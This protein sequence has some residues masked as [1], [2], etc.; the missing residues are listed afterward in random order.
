MEDSLSRREFLEA[1]AGVAVGAGLVATQVAASA[2]ESK[3]PLKKAL[4][5]SMLPRDLSME[6]KFQLAKAVGFDGVEIAPVDEAQAQAMR[7]AAEKAG[8]RIHSIIFG[9]WHAPLSSADATVIER[10]LRDMQSALRCAKT[11][12]ADVVLLVPAVVN[13][14]TRYVEA[15]ERSQKHIRTLIPLA[16]ELGVVIAVENVWNKFL[17]SP[18]EFAR[19]VDEFESPFVRAYFDVGNVVLFGFPQD[20]IRTL[21][22]RIVKVHLKDFKQQSNQ[23]VALRE[24][25]VNW[26]EVRRALDEIGYADFLT[27]ELPGGDEAYLRDVSARVDKIIAG[28]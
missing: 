17:L 2:Q 27:T 12:G 10:G 9:G 7:A 20:W 5:F 13:E 24:G 25:D 11:V 6:G 18:I 22:K 21:G 1:S 26:K 4:I 19:Y 3:S 15:Y 14:S 16:Q 23:F 28:E 8:V